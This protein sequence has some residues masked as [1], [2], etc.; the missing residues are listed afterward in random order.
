M[1]KVLAVDYVAQIAAQIEPKA[2]RITH[3]LSN[4]WLHWHRQ[5]AELK[6]HDQEECL[7]KAAGT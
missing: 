1:G 5:I 6:P 3:L 7:T 2:S 4:F